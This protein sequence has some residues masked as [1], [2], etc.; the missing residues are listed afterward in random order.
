MADEAFLTDFTRQHR[1][2]SDGLDRRYSALSDVVERWSVDKLVSTSPDEVLA[3]MWALEYARAGQQQPIRPQ[4]GLGAPRVFEDPTA[5]QMYPPMDADDPGLPDAG[6]C[7]NVWHWFVTWEVRWPADLAGYWPDRHDEGLTSQEAHPDFGQP[8]TTYWRWRD[9]SDGQREIVARCSVVKTSAPPQL[10][11]DLIV[12]AAAQIQR[13]ADGFGRQIEDWVDASTVEF[14]SRL[15]ERRRRALETRKAWL[16]VNDRLE[17]FRTPELRVEARPRPPS[18]VPKVVSAPPLLGIGSAS[19][20]SVVQVI[21]RWASAVEKYAGSFRELEEERISDLLVATLNG[22]FGR[23]EREVFIGTGKSDF[24]VS[25]DALGESGV[26]SVFTG[27][28]K[29]WK[30]PVDFVAA[31]RQA[32]L[33]VVGRTPEVVLIILDV[34]V[35]WNHVMTEIERMLDS[36]PGGSRRCERIADRHVVALRNPADEQSEVRLC[37]VPVNMTRPSSLDPRPKGAG[38]RRH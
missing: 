27:E 12:E 28:V 29:K 11:E 14:R 7:V 15:E 30:G 36:L 31:T 2:L 16:A 37:V 22:A 32:I 24:Y 13:Y 35:T 19:M 1:K 21:N 23:A 5:A 20:T 18:S 3:E 10:P 6:S 25:G 38:R 26:F 9:R 34:D 17:A 8:P 4:F 33:N